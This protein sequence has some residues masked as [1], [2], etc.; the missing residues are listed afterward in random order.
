[1]NS[2]PGPNTIDSPGCSPDALTVAAVNPNG[3]VASFSSRGGSTYPG[4]P[5]CA[6]PGVLI[7]SGT[8]QLSPMALEQPKAGYG[9]VAISGTSM[10]T[11]HVAGLV[12]LLKQRT[13]TLTTPE[14]ESY[15]GF[16]GRPMEPGYRFRRSQL[17][18][19][20]TRRY[21]IME[22]KTIQPPK[23]PTMPTKLP[24]E[25]QIS[26]GVDRFLD[27]MEKEPIHKGI[28]RVV[29]KIPIMPSSNI[30]TPL[31]TYKTPEFYVPKILP[32]RFDTTHREAF[33]AASPG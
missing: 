27:F 13:P 31:G 17:E 33:K 15:P 1:M 2:G 21:I 24:G 28:N 12:A 10:A 3:S 22:R 30:K 19:V 29:E 8:S 25:D 32:A 26:A 7:Y 23:W 5:D 20:L 14:I 16:E 18:Y 4:K 11:P 6:A 9:Y